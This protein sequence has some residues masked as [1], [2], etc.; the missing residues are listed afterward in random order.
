MLLN[1]DI[2]I[3]ISPSQ[4]SSIYYLA[5]IQTTYI[6]VTVTVIKERELYERYTLLILYVILGATSEIKIE[7]QNKN[8]MNVS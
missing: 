7:E 3:Q 6:Y 4:F 1:V 5:P 8:G 2:S